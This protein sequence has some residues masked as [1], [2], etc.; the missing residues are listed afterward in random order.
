MLSNNGLAF[1]QVGSSFHMTL[2][3]FVEYELIEQVLLYL[4]NLSQ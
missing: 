1:I 4:H 3:R 2:I